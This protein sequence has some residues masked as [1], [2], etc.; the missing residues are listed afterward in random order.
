MV[1]KLIEKN[2]DKGLLT[3]EDQYLAKYKSKTDFKS[4]SKATER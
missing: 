4:T 2:R 3:T 1:I